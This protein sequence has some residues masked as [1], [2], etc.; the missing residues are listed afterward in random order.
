[1]GDEEAAIN[2]LERARNW[3]VPERRWKL[4]CAFLV[5]AASFALIQHN[6]ALA[7]DLIS[8]LETVAWGRENVVPMPGPYWKLR[9]FKK[10][11]LGHLDEAHGIVRLFSERWKTSCPFHYLDILAGRAW[12]ERQDNGI[13]SEET[14]TELMLFDNMKAIGRRALFA[15]QGFLTPVKTPSSMKGFATNESPAIL[16][17]RS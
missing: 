7:L 6:H 3:L 9:V 5:E 8:Q 2:C 16:T 12:L 17:S 1:M 4:H 14:E 10:G 15:S 13:V 11:L